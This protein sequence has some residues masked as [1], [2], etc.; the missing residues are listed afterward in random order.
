MENHYMAFCCV[1]EKG[2][3]IK[4]FSIT[5]YVDSYLPH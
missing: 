2:G 4:I 3:E 1:F 5:G